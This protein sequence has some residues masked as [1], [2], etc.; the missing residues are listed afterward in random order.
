MGTKRLY[1]CIDS[2][3]R[4]FSLDIDSLLLCGW[5]DIHID[6]VGD[7]IAAPEHQHPLMLGEREVCRLYSKY[8]SSADPPYYLVLLRDMQ[9]AT[10]QRKVILSSAF[11]AYDDFETPLADMPPLDILRMLAER[12]GLDVLG[13]KFILHQCIPKKDVE[14]AIP[15]L[16]LDD[17]SQAI[18]TLFWRRKGPPVEL[19]V[20]LCFALDKRK[21]LDYVERKTKG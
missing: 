12:F 6:H 1:S 4:R 21:Y 18:T 15:K 11:K 8:T 7:A 14:D 10:E 20:V 19:E 17:K 2:H 13:E 16:Q 9:T 3:G 5:L